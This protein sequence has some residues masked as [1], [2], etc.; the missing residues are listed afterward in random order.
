MTTPEQ[1]YA[2]QK[3]VAEYDSATD[4]LILDSLQFDTLDTKG[5]PLNVIVK[6]LRKSF[7]E[8]ITHDKIL[9]EPIRDDLDFSDG[10]CMISSYLIYSMTGGDKVW[11]LRG[12]PTHWWLYH[13]K[14][15]LIFDI[16]H[17]QFKSEDLP[18][19]YALGEPVNKLK[20]DPMFYD[21]LKQK[22]KL[23]AHYAELE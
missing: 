10:F 7:K 14:T 18:G 21:E 5:V 9:N 8:R 6:L 23:L 22:A 16:T 15:K 1:F 13:K 4:K 17:T 11:Q 20:T 19:I 12:T 3:K 2:A